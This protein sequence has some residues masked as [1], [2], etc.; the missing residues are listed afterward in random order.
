MLIGI[1]PDTTK[2]LEYHLE[3]NLENISYACLV[4]YVPYPSENGLKRAINVGEKYYNAAKKFDNLMNVNYAMKEVDDRIARLTYCGKTSFIRCQINKI[5][6]D[7]NLSD[8]KCI[9][10]IN[11]ESNFDEQIIK[12][13]VKDI[14]R[15]K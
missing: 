15:S 4:P 3:L 7:K 12:N 9:S 14:K 5:K 11:N 8:E 6:D 1:L 2:G 10:V 13:V